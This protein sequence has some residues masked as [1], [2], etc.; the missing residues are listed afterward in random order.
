MHIHVGKKATFK[1]CKIWLEPK[2]E[3]SDVGEL[4][5]KQQ[6]EVLE[7]VKAYKNELIK[8]WKDFVNGKNIKV[9]KVK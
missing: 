7:I 8:Q 5:Q 6:N 2:I 4:S 3:I 9:I 1:L